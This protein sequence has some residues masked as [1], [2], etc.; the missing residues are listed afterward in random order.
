MVDSWLIV[1]NR[2]GQYTFA[3]HGRITVTEPSTVPGLCLGEKGNRKNRQPSFKKNQ[4]AR[5]ETIIET[6]VVTGSVLVPKF[7]SA[8]VTSAVALSFR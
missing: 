6:S 7:S 4:M 5:Q 2:E 8:S 1:R 3:H